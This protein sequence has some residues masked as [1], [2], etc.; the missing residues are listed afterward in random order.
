[1]SS[2]C[3]TAEHLN[4]SSVSCPWVFRYSWWI[5]DEG[6]HKVQRKTGALSI[7]FPDVWSILSMTYIL[8]LFVKDLVK[9]IAVLLKHQSTFRKISCCTIIDPTFDLYAW[10]CKAV[11]TNVRLFL[12]VWTLQVQPFLDLWAHSWQKYSTFLAEW[13]SD[14][15]PCGEGVVRVLG[16]MVWSDLPCRSDRNV[17]WVSL[18]PIPASGDFEHAL[19]YPGQG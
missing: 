2:S 14:H 8:T 3:Q 1:M 6:P 7:S 17:L 13:Q 19:T 9:S 15:V 11:I 18:K 4:R 12:G 16:W 10:T 5:A